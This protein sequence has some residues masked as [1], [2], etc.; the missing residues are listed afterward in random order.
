MGC[1]MQASIKTKVGGSLLIKV[2]ILMV[3]YVT[4]TA[5]YALPLSK[6]V[7]LAAWKMVLGYIT[8]I[9]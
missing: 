1:Y 4:F 9:P 6:A 2:I 5:I 7:F 8:V 3:S